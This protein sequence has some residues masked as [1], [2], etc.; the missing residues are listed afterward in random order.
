MKFWLNKKTMSW[1]SLVVGAGAAG[2]IAGS[3]LSGRGSLPDEEIPAETAQVWTCSMHPQIRLPNSGQCPVCAMDLIPV[4]MP[5]ARDDLGPRQL[6]LS[7]TARQLAALRLAPVERRPVQV[8]TR[9]AGKIS[10]DE[11]RLKYV[12][13]WV[14]GRIDRLYVDYTGVAVEPGDHMVYIYS[15]ELLAAQQELIQ[16]LAGAEA[17]GP[18]GLAT[19]AAA[20]DRLQLLGLTSGQIA[21]IEQSRQPADHLT[22]YAP[23][24]GTVVAKHVNEGAYVQTGTRIYTLA[25]LDRVWLELAAY[26]SDLPWI[27]YGQEVRFTTPAHPGEVFSGRVS[28]ISPFLDEP[29][30]TVTVRVD[31]DNTRAR[32]KP[33]LFARAVAYAQVSAHGRAAA[34]SLA[35]KWISPMHP[36]IVRDEPGSC[37]VCG[38]DLEPAEALG[39]AGEPAAVQD[40]LV[41]P[42]SAVLQ[43]GERAVVY[44]AVAGKSGLY[45]GREVVLGPRAGDFYVIH[46]G[47]AAGE[48][49]VVEGNFKIDSALQILARPSMMNPEGGGPPPVHH[50]HGEHRAPEEG[51]PAAVHDPE[52]HRP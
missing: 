34:P 5:S 10:Y 4:A 44:V 50:H 15:P 23:V 42:A 45:E 43:T 26:E 24:G 52:G 28:F 17:L 18:A 49:V 40:P 22:I 20:R 7:E 6:E 37:P 11:T 46:E 48:E 21:A 39:L 35:G 30:R 32:L 3:G 47:L 51:H 31:V 41:V 14:A 13:A 12:T 9:M 38:M 19:V 33:G 29:T 1:I 27:H 8:E 36:E 16:A 2:L 25:D